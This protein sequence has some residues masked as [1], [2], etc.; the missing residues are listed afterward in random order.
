A[1]PDRA[2]K[3]PEPLLRVA[4]VVQAIRAEEDNVAGGCPSARAVGARRQG[5]TNREG[6]QQVVLVRQAPSSV[7][8]GPLVDVLRVLRSP[9]REDGGIERGR[10]RVLEVVR[11][12]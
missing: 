8:P 7:L 1:Q 10:R 6:V 11:R 2:L 5:V 9:T 4:A 3:E 12:P